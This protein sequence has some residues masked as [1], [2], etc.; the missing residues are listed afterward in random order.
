MIVTGALVGACSKEQQSAVKVRP[1]AAPRIL[2]VV[3]TPT[4]TSETDQSS[5]P[6]SPVAPLTPMMQSS[7]ITWKI[8]PPS[9]TLEVASIPTMDRTTPVPPTSLTAQMVQCL[10]YEVKP[11]HKLVLTYGVAGE[12]LEVHVK[13]ACPQTFSADDSWFEVR[14]LD[15]GGRVI[16]KETGRFQSEIGARGTADTIIQLDHCCD[17]MKRIKYEGSVWW[18]AG[19]GKGPKTPGP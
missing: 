12:Q 18:A 4:A 9:P 11:N 13:N 14:A 8:P 1:T 15:E 2:Y 6:L 19:G 5:P 16:A 10:A 3:A 17:P 7:E